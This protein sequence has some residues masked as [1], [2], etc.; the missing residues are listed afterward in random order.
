MIMNLLLW[1]LLGAVAG[2]IASFV[3][4]GRGW[5]T[6]TII[7]VIGAISGGFVMN[8]FGKTGITG[9]NV[10]SLIIAIIGAIV[11]L[12]ILPRRYGCSYDR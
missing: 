4:G 5:L 9:F 7:G 6:N 2:W 1:A 12:L 11:L 3:I 8:A 10:Y